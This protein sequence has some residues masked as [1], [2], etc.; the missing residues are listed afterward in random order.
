MGPPAAIGRPVPHSVAP[1]A[2]G[3][4]IPPGDRICWA[5]ADRNEHHGQPYRPLPALGV[6]CVATS[7]LAAD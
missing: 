6:G 5:A 2:R 1:S 7:T 3:I 4:L